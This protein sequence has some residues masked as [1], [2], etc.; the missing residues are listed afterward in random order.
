MKTA[1]N[2]YALWFLFLVIGLVSFVICVTCIN[3]CGLQADAAPGVSAT[4]PAP[5]ATDT[6]PDVFMTS[7]PCDF[8]FSEHYVSGATTGEMRGDLPLNTWTAGMKLADDNGDGYMGM[9]WTSKVPVGTFN[10]SYVG[11]QGANMNP[12]WAQ[13][14]LAEDLSHMSAKG[15]AYVQCN[16]YD[17]ATGAINVVPEPSCD[18]RITVDEACNIT[19]AGNMGNFASK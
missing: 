8:N 3:G 6:F 15:R 11:Y 17:A 9:T 14:G 13:Y 18:I 12:A 7:G 1:Q 16:W 5:V 10:L 4:V 2:D 19:P